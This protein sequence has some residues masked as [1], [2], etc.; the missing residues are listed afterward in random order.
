MRCIH[1]GGIGVGSC[2]IM[3]ADVNVVTAIVNVILLV[4]ISY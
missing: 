3:E 2:I 1:S 4:R